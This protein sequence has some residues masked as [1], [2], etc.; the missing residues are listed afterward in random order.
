VDS[1]CACAAEPGRSDHEGIEAKE[2]EFGRTGF[3]EEV[4]TKS[5]DDQELAKHCVARANAIGGRLLIGVEDKDDL[6]PPEQ[7]MDDRLL[8]QISKRISQL[9]LNVGIAPH[10]VTAANGGEYIELK[11]FRSHSLAATSD[12]RYFIR[13]ADESRPLLPD[14]LGRLMNDKTAFVWETQTS[15]LV[16]RQ[17]F[18]E[19]KY[20]QFLTAIRHSE[21]VSAFLK[22]KSDEEVLE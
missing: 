22:E 4:F 10:Q 8:S 15:P 14:E 1:R 13:V 5:E 21:R 18:D 6:P 2:N 11:I 19:T 20:R 7:R 3:R 17:R 16:P 9:T 12:G